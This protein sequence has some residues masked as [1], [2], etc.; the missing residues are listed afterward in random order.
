[1]LDSL[2]RVFIFLSLFW[3]SLDL[4]GLRREVRKCLSILY[5]AVDQNDV[6][7]NSDPGAGS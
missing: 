2:W 1:M 4:I 5:D 6:R 7:Q 3:I